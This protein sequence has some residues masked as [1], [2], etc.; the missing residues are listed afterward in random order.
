MFGLPIET[1]MLLFGF[2]VFWVLYTLVF[3]YISRDWSKENET[4]DDTS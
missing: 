4:E 3:A 2:P 1:A